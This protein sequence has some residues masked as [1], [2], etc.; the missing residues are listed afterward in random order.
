MEIVYESFTLVACVQCF[1]L[2]TD[3]KQAVARGVLKNPPPVKE[4]L[5]SS[6]DPLECTKRS[7]ITV[8]L[9][10]NAADINLDTVLLSNQPIARAYMF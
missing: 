2:Q 4:S 1:H 3:S 8:C 6:K 5:R 7:T 10:N 9:I